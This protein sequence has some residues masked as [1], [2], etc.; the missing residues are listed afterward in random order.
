[1]TFSRK[2]LV[3]LAAG[4]ATGLVLGELVAPLQIVADGFVRLLQMT[5]LPYVTIS[6]IVSLGSL[7]M[8]QARLLGLRGGLVVLGLWAIAF[9]VTW[10]MPLTWP[11]TETASFFST[12]LVERRPPFDFVALY[13]PVQSVQC[14]RQQRRA[15][16]RALLGGGRHCADRRRTESDAPRSAAHGGD[17]DRPRHARRRRPH[18]LRAVRD[19]GGGRRH[20]HDRGDA[21]DPDLP[22]HLLRHVDDRRAVGPARADCRIDGPPHPRPVRAPARFADRRLRRRRSVHRAA[23]TDRGVQ[24]AARHAQSRRVVRAGLER[25]RRRARRDRAGLV[26]LPAC[27]QAALAQ[28]RAVRRLV[29]RRGPAAPRLPAAVRRRAAVVLRQPEQRRAVSAGPVRPAGGHLP[30][31]PRHGRDQLTVRHAR[32][33][34]AHGDRGDCRER[35]RH[36]RPALALPAADAV[37]RRDGHSSWR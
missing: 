6:I 37:R 11:D 35:R 7:N 3:G 10:L 5:V 4:V 25:A 9:A 15:R 12:T 30:A 13:I 2:I 14:A 27:R 16:R 21:A 32:R 20:A 26:Q 1:M 22:G 8:Q 17:D 36:G 31:V 19:C 24:G 34:D 18:A 33:R 23:G 29:L 28:L